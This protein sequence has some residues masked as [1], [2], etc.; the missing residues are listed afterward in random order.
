MK[1]TVIDSKS[2]SEIAIEG[3]QELKGQRIALMDLREVGS[4]ITDYFVICTGTSDRHVQSLAE[5][6]EKI[7]KDHGERPIAVEGTQT[8][9]WVLIDYVSIVV[10]IFLQEKREFFRLEELWG[11]ARFTFIEDN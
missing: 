2:L 11:D 9:E 1:Q 10:H 5:S 6:V 8:G 4:A 7:M 3:L